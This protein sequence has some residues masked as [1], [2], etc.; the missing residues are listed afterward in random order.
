MMTCRGIAVLFFLTGQ[1]ALAAANDGTPAWF[2]EYGSGMQD[3]KQSG[4]MLLVYFHKDKLSIEQ[5]KLYQKISGDAK[6]QPLVA[7]YSLVRI[8]V[9]KRATVGGKEIRLIDHVSFRELEGRS[10][11]AI[12]DFSDPKSR[13]YGHVVSIYPENLPGATT[14]RHLTVLLQLPPG[15][16]TQRTLILAVKIHPEHPGSTDGVF[17][18]TLA[19]ET[20]SHSQYQARITNQGH[21]N[22][23]SR[24]HRINSRLPGGYL[25][26]EVCARELARQRADCRGAGLR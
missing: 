3:A 4:H 23:E 25:A 13:Y 9:S 16:L 21:H 11:I 1:V 24:F 22:W 7:N 15:S 10:G 17:L 26:V 18:A 12:I 19:K 2:D 14:T 5:D 20:E 6:L 8:A